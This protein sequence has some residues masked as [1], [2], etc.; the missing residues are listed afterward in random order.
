MLLVWDHAPA[1]TTKPVQA[2]LEATGIEVAWLPF[3]SPELNPC[4]ALW[5]HLKRLI[6]ANRVY[7][8]VAQ[9]ADRA[10]RWLEDLARDTVLGYAGL[11]SSKFSR[12]PT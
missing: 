10:V 3:R 5:R 7:P 9:L 12:L 11:H 2:A 4:E 6:T 8:A 1:H